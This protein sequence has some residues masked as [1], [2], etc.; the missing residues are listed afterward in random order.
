MSF[1]G[2]GVLKGVGD[3]GDVVEDVVV[4]IVKVSLRDTRHKFDACV[5]NDVDVTK[6]DT[7]NIWPPSR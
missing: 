6:S 2:F 3:F 5:G 7:N 4:D 1:E